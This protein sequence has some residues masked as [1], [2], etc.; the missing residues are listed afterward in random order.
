MKKFL[1]D[2]KSNIRQVLEIILLITITTAPI[3][4]DLRKLFKDYLT[5]NFL[6]PDN[7]I[8][9]TAIAHGKYM[10]SVVLFFFTLWLIRKFNSD[11]VMNRR[12]VYH[13][14]HY[15]WYW[16]CAKVLGIKRCNLILVPI[17]MQFE[18]VTRGTFEEYPLDDDDYP[19]I[20]GE[21]ECRVTKKN[22]TVNYNEINIILEDT[23]T[24]KDYQIPESKK[25]LFTL[26]ISRNDGNSNGRHF[27]QKFIETTINAVRQFKRV[28]IA[29]VY[30]TTNPKNTLHIAKRVFA[31]GDRGNIEHLY[32]FQQEKDGQRFFEPTGH[33]IY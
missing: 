1:D 3:L 7:F 31:L 24:I 8:W 10:A 27:S 14:Y 32:V 19:I 28:S 25:K 2:I 33:K 17:Y 5:S 4:V 11:Y 16:F 12:S 15:L 9:Y 26:R 30:A 22:N 6:T 20:D 23:Y 13:D 21:P 29:N 18:L